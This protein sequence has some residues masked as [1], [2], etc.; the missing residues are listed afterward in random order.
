VWSSDG[1]ARVVSVADWHDCNNAAGQ[2]HLIRTEGW[3]PATMSVGNWNLQNGSGANSAVV[4]QAR[5]GDLAEVAGRTNWD[6]VL[7]P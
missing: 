1:K 5:C 2:V 6:P 7:G 4:A 3:S